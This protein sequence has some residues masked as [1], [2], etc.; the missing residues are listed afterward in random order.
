[1]EFS[2]GPKVSIT[3]LMD[4]RVP[5]G[6]SMGIMCMLLQGDPPITFRWLKEGRSVDNIPGIKVDSQ[7]GISHIIISMANEAHTGNYTCVASNLVGSSF[8]IAEVLVNGDPQ[9]SL[10]SES[11]S[12]GKNLCSRQIVPYISEEIDNNMKSKP[13]VSKIK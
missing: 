10:F 12:K 6:A 1:M 7:E 13:C 5:A 2:V 8:V 3:S 9:L 4:K 11:L